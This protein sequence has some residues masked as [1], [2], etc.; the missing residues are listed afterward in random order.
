MTDNLTPSITVQEFNTPEE[1]EKAIEQLASRCS[2]LPQAKQAFLA[3]LIQTNTLELEVLALLVLMLE[4]SDD[5]FNIT[6]PELNN[7]IRQS[8]SAMEKP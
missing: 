2:A 5:D 3:H 6:S 7:L 1:I 8:Q 4:N